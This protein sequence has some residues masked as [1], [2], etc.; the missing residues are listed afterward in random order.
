MGKIAGLTSTLTAAGTCAGPVLAGFLFG[1]GGYWPAWVG[2]AVFLVVDI[3]MRV[4]LI[5]RPK[6]PRESKCRGYIDTGK[7]GKREKRKRRV[8]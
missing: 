8:H 6:A 7:R 2:P 3:V 4:L 1:L 5:D